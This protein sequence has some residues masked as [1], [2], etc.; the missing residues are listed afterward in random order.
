M[1]YIAFAS[2]NAIKNSNHDELALSG[3]YASGAHYLF[4]NISKANRLINLAKKS[5]SVSGRMAWYTRSVFFE[6]RIMFETGDYQKALSL[7]ERL[8]EEMNG[9]AETNAY[10]TIS[11]WAYRC[12][13][14]L[15]GVPAGE[16]IRHNIDFLLFE[17]EACY[18]A[19]DYE[20]AAR[21]A[22]AFIEHIPE[23]VFQF[24]EQPDWSSGFSGIE[25]ILFEK[26]DFLVRFATAYRCL[27]V[28]HIDTQ[29]AA[30]A[31]HDMEH[32]MRNERFNGSDP[33]NP[34]LFYAYFQALEEAGAPE[35]D[36]NTAIS[37]AFKCLQ[38]RASRIDGL[39]T[40]RNFLHLPF[41]NKALY[42]RAKDYKL[43]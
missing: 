18:F 35:V 36:K 10:Q 6:G 3:Y 43:I 24:V 23:P 42:Q 28:C 19:G 7:F 16:Y 2:D 32:L 31:A 38:S 37:M 22:D 26:R 41:W 5:A 15:N 1:D 12:K 21:K 4:G 30:E 29:N 39:D 14:F 17:I 27:S 20:S 11:A 9:K 33:N 25:F 13:I 40:K 34:F 8:L